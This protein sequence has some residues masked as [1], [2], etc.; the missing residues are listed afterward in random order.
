VRHLAEPLPLHE[1]ARAAH[2]SPYHFHRVFRAITGETLNPFV[3][4]LR[5][6]RSLSLRLRHPRRTL[7][8]VALASGFTSLS[9]FS[10]CF[11]QRFGISP[12]AF[13][14]AAHRAH[15]RESL[16]RTLPDGGER[17]AR[18]PPGQNPDG[19]EVRLRRLPARTVA[20]LRVADSYREGAVVDAASRLFEWADTRGLAGGQWLGYMWDDPE[21]V[22]LANCR[23]DV[24]LTVPDEVPIGGGVS[25]CRFAPVQ[26][27]ELTL[28]GGIDLELRALDWLYGTWLP[29]SDFVP[30]DQPCFEAWIGRPFAHGLEHFELEVWLPVQRA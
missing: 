18:L 15:Q 2:L 10:R 22:A 4:R 6:E 24:G 29:S 14:L 3:T 9:D 30:A 23:Y 26:V 1:V 11:K 16:Q 21:V 17:L 13:D 20:Y 8:E 27:A 12:S 25:R 28:R 7:T 19:F 5:L